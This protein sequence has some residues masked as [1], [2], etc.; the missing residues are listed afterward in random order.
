MKENYVKRNIKK[1]HVCG[2]ANEFGI[3]SKRP[4]FRFP[5]TSSSH[6][7]AVIREIKKKERNISLEIN[8]EMMKE[9]S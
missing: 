4:H 2:N 5:L 7:I 9:T 8:I 1:N 6:H 3:V